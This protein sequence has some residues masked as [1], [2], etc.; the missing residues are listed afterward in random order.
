MAEENSD[1]HPISPA[2]LGLIAFLS[3]GGLI[4]LGITAKLTGHAYAEIDSSNAV[5]CTTQTW[6]N[7]PIG[8]VQGQAWTT[9]IYCNPYES[10]A[11]C[12]LHQIAQIARAPVDVVGVR[13]GACH[14]SVPQASYP[15]WV[16]S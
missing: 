4:F 10:M 7:A 15:I 16:Q 1:E 9:T 11:S 14:P 13:I 6:Q 2:I 3:I 12:C 8:Y 5:C